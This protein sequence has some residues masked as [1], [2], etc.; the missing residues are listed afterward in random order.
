MLTCTLLFPQDFERGMVDKNSARNLVRDLEEYAIFLI[1]REEIERLELILP[2]QEYALLKEKISQGRIRCRVRSEASNDDDHLFEVRLS[3]EGN[4]SAPALWASTLDAFVECPPV[5][6][7]RNFRH[8]VSEPSDREDFY[9]SILEPMLRAMPRARSLVD[10]VDPYL[11]DDFLRF[12]RDRPIGASGL[13]WLMH[14]FAQFTRRIEN[15]VSVRLFTTTHRDSSLK[16]MGEIR[17]LFEMFRSADLD[18]LKIDVYVVPTSQLKGEKSRIA[19]DTL[20]HRRIVSSTLKGSWIYLGL[21]RG[22]S[23]LNLPQDGSK[24]RAC[25]TFNYLPFIP[26]TSERHNANE[27]IDLVPRDHHFRI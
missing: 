12:T 10:L 3:P 23:D 14:L 7:R 9:R 2:T 20:H 13:G 27:I 15:P 24:S 5:L 11:I 4:F 26:A 19:A 1:T 17:K 8:G 25:S 21:D 22:I 6:Q 18:A 16:D